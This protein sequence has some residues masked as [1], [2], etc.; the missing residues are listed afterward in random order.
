MHMHTRTRVALRW[1][2]L[3]H[4][5]ALGRVALY[6]VGTTPHCTSCRG[7]QRLGL[8]GCSSFSCANEFGATGALGGDVCDA[9]GRWYSPW[10]G[11]LNVSRFPRLGVDIRDRSGNPEAPRPPESPE[12]SGGQGRLPGADGAPLLCLDLRQHNQAASVRLQDQ[13]LRH[14]LQW[15]VFHH[16]GYRAQPCEAG[17]RQGTRNVFEEYKRQHPAHSLQT[18]GQ[19]FAPPRAV[20]THLYRHLSLW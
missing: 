4:L 15:Q 14:I 12:S 17:V 5:L 13:V 19:V 7:L 2:C 11:C 16:A 9:R 8:G 18:V 6:C 1:Q 10:L 20:L 3:G